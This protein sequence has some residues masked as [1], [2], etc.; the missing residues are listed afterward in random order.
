MIPG[1]TRL[2][3]TPGRPL[4]AEVKAGYI[5][6]HIHQY[7]PGRH[8]GRHIHQYTPWETQGGIQPGIHHGVYPEY[9]Q[10]GIHPGV[11]TDGGT[12]WGIHRRRYTLGYTG[13]IPGWV[14]RWDTRVCTTVG[15]R[16][17]WYTTVGERHAWYTTVGRVVCPLCT[18][19][20]GWYA[21]YV[22]PGIWYPVYT[23]WYTP[24][25]QV[26]PTDTVVPLRLHR[27]TTMRSD[28]L[29][30]SKRE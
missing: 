3:N 30:G 8:I 13:G 28:D 4:C 5:G 14:Q 24:P 18:T 11:Y 23:P 10:P 22:H 19:W 17:A 16:H 12:L 6:R 15:E 21:R 2:F 26:H 27:G 1:L 9:I 20:I 25:S 7:T 29:P